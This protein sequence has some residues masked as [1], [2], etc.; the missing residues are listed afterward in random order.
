[1][2]CRNCLIT[3]VYLRR[4]SSGGG[5]TTTREQNAANHYTV[6]IGTISLGFWCSR[7]QLCVLIIEC[8]PFGPAVGNGTALNHLD[9]CSLQRGYDSCLNRVRAVVAETVHA[10]CVM[11][12]G[13]WTMSNDCRVSSAVVGGHCNR[14]CPHGSPSCIHA[15]FDAPLIAAVCASCKF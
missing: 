1:M 9:R 14:L 13:L 7:L 11:R 4:L 2:L 6:M 15:I 8:R 10:S 12:M 5:L 3:R